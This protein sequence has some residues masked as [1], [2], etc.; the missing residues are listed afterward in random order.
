V[1]E[2]IELLREIIRIENLSGK[3]EIKSY[4]ENVLR[5]RRLWVAE[6]YRVVDAQQ[7]Q[8]D[9]EADTARVRRAV[10]ECLGA[11][12]VREIM[13]QKEPS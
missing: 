1:S 5:V 6:S 4:A 13:S 2:D 3:D 8:A 11:E 7:A 10:R 9:A 12:A